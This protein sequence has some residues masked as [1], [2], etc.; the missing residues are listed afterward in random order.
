LLGA[1]EPVGE[2]VGDRDPVML[3]RVTRISVCVAYWQHEASFFALSLG[4]P[5][6]QA[7]QTSR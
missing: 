3:R 1:E 4:L 6:L 7:K 5:I 2:A